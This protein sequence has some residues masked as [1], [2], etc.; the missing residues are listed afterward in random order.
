MSDT[1]IPAVRSLPDLTIDDR[2]TVGGKGASLGELLRAG[3]RV[4]PGFVVTTAGFKTALGVIDPD[5]EL[6][7]RLESLSHTDSRG[8]EEV[9][10]E[11]RRRV[12]DTPLPDELQATLTSH[13]R[14]LGEQGGETDPPVAV[15]SSA[16]GEDSADASFAGLQDTFLFVRGAEEV[17]DKV[18]ACWASLYNVESVTYR[19]GRELAEDDMA[20]AVVVQRMVDARCSGVMFTC[21]PVSGDRSVVALEASW[22]LGSA[23]V[24]GEVTP[25]SYTIS[26]VT[27]E[28][29]RREVAAKLV[30]HRMDPSGRG[31]ETADVPDELQSE[32]C[33]TDEQLRAL[34]ELAR[35]VEDH[36]GVPQDIE[37][38]MPEEPVEGQE[39][40]LLQSRPE[41]VWAHRQ[42]TPLA[43]PRGRPYDHVLDFLSGGARQKDGGQGEGSS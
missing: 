15:R 35:R 24:G 1:T 39:I 6:R 34:V 28:I 41:T 27:G 5:H 42:R 40:L 30:Q 22:G 7:N 29:I 13:Y 20:M 4:P 8:I 12:L 10:T 19:R 17:I 18:R 16:T 9:A 33:L 43:K 23:M 11:L 36:Y 21:S 3:I 2:P 38:A 26:K 32:P 31:V 37:W 14:D 25:D